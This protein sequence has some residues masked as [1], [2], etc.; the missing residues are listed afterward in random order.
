M[1]GFMKTYFNFIMHRI[2]GTVGINLQLEFVSPAP[3]EGFAALESL[4]LKRYPYW[5]SLNAL[6][7]NVLD[8]FSFKVPYGTL[9]TDI[10]Y[11]FKEIN[12]FI[13]IFLTGMEN[14]CGLN[15]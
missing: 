12:Q 4:S 2:F 13:D 14:F 3:D 7:I 11:I 5:G 6:F 15:L 8:D 10:E 9:K 1:A